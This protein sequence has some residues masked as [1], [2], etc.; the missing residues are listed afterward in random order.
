M[1]WEYIIDAILA[2]LLIVLTRYAVPA[3]QQY[4][5]SKNRAQLVATITE[6]V[7]AAEQLF[8]AE[9]TGE[10]KLQYVQ[11][12]LVEKGVELTTEIRAIIESAVYKLKDDRKNAEE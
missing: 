9:K 8:P 10:Q 2:I 6:L 12:L 4:I 11:N 5:N 3:L 1:N 7:A